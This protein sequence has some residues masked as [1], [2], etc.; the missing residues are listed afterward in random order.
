ML[1][2][3]IA[4][5]MATCLRTG[6]ADQ[7]EF[8]T[9]PRL[10]L[11][12]TD[13]SAQLEQIK[14]NHSE[15]LNLRSELFQL[16]ELLS[17]PGPQQGRDAIVGD[18]QVDEVSKRSDEIE[19]KEAISSSRNAI[20]TNNDSPPDPRDKSPRGYYRRHTLLR[21]FSEIPRL[22]PF[23]KETADQWL[24]PYGIYIK[25]N[26]S[27]RDDG[28]R[29][30]MASQEQP[31]LANH[32]PPKGDTD[33][34]VAI[35]LNNFE[36]L[37]RIV[38]V[39]TFSREYMNFWT[40]GRTRYPTMAAMIL[41][42]LAVSISAA[43]QIAGSSPIPAVYR[44]MSEQWIAAVDDWLRLQSSKHRKLVHYQ[45]SC[46]I[47]I[48]RRMHVVNK[49]R[50]WKDTG[51][52]IQDAITDGLHRNPPLTDTLFIRE[53]KKRIWFTVRELELQNSFEC[54]LLTLL[55]NIEC[56]VEAPVNLADE[57]FDD[58]TVHSPIERLPNYYTESSYQFHS[59]RSWSLRLEISRRLFG[60]GAF[61]IPEYDEVLRYTHEITKA[62][63]DLPPWGNCRAGDKRDPYLFLTF[64]MLEFQL[65]ECLL[66]LH[67]PYVDRDDGKYPLSE[68][69]CYQTSREILFSNIGL[70]NLGVQSLAQ[71]REDL[72]IA[73]LH[74]T[75]ITLL[76]PEGSAS[77]IMSNAMSTVDLL[78]QCLPIIEEKYLRVADPWIFFIMCT[79]IMLIKMHLG[80]ESRQTAKSSCARRFL[81]LYYKNVWMR[82]PAD[83]AQQQAITQDIV[84][85]TNAAACP[86]SSADGSALPTS[87]WL[88]SSYPDI[89]NDPFD[90]AVGLD[91]VWDES[92]FPLPGFPNC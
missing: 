17:R 66:A 81:D 76:Q 20:S 68:N 71:L 77:I 5:A 8:E 48:A 67:R 14:S 31:L 88:D 78:E 26:K 33:A 29:M 21:F 83:L 49:K 53:M 52:L 72:S 84:N 30:K 11:P 40:P 12:P 59:F 28:W 25:K 34:L 73:S 16:R 79:A 24:K 7:C 3:S 64:S 56:D 62:I 35:Y 90:L 10:G 9:K 1:K 13:N 69:V 63:N 57:D 55:H 47:Y 18:V 80:K 82:Q 50:F 44:H 85:Q 19:A 91:D 23:I 39:P 43:P 86:P 45:V 60:S 65:K 70:A 46:L 92:G 22:F 87:V 74:M 75:R 15:I 2:S 42:M 27:A 58:A 6:R 36:Q 32:L 54:G 41:S 37:H 89:G 61:R 51:S 4:T 38:H